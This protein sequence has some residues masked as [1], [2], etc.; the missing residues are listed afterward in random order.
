MFVT[1]KVHSLKRQRKMQYRFLVFVPRR[2]R[3]SLTTLPCTFVE[4]SI[5]IN[6]IFTNLFSVSILHLL[7]YKSTLFMK[8]FCFI[9]I[10]NAFLYQFAPFD[11]LFVFCIGFRRLCQRLFILYLQDH[12]QG[13]CRP[14]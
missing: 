14:P 8:L 1:Q 12:Q 6:L 9:I 13:H 7:K 2:S 11:T 10:S 3:T 4:I 5:L